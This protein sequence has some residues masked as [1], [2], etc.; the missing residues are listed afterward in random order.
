M[1]ITTCK[2][3]KEKIFV[4]M[5]PGQ[6]SL[7]PCGDESLNLIY[8]NGPKVSRFSKGGDTIMI[9]PFSIILVGRDAKADISIPP[10]GHGVA[11]Y[12]DYVN[13]NCQT[14]VCSFLEENEVNFSNSYSLLPMNDVLRC[15]F[16]TMD[17]NLFELYDEKNFRDVKFMEFCHI[18]CQWLETSDF[19][20]FLY[21][22]MT[23]NDPA[24]RRLVLEN[25]VNS[26]RVKTL[27]STCGLTEKQFTE[28]FRKEF[29]ESPK[30]WITNQA[31]KD[32][33]EM[34]TDPNMS[35]KEMSDTLKMSSVQSFTRFCKSKTGM[36]P[37]RLRSEMIR[38]SD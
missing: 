8:M 3:R 16:R 7:L 28:K 1:D 29:G 25:Y 26:Y 11:L 27:A 6:H 21:P 2:L 4:Y 18:L 5:S 22:A 15:F 36:T 33:K 9:P 19:V 24:F 30:I 31:V 32:M 35:F 14:M 13:R 17:K 23:W 37:T 10:E 12:F 20:E 38:L 34:M